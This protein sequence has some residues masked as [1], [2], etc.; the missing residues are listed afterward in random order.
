MSEDSEVVLAVLLGEEELATA[1]EVAFFDSL[2]RF[3]LGEK[4][5]VRVY[6]VHLQM[7][8]VYIQFVQCIMCMCIPF[9]IHV[10]VCVCVYVYTICHTR[11]HA[12]TYARACTHTHTHTRTH[13]H[14]HTHTHTV[15]VSAKDTW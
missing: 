7:S 13:A 5:C 11:T 10:C 6:N 3:N 9:V 8:Y 2:R 4:T 14:T 12:H 1:E 15:I